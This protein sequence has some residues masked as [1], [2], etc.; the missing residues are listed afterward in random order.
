MPFCC[1]FLVQA[2]EE[3]KKSKKRSLKESP[4][5]WVILDRKFLDEYNV[6][7]KKNIK[8]VRNILQKIKDSTRLIF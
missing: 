6:S 3:I 7:M 2:S 8:N 4:L 5:D 1:Y